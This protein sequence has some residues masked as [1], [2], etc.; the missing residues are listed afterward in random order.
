[1]PRKRLFTQ[2]E[3]DEKR[4]AYQREYT[5]REHVKKEEIKLIRN[6]E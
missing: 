1:M 2:E 4:R 6:E 5:K 3:L